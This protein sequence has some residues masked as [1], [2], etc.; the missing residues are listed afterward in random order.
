MRPLSGADLLA[1]WTEFASQLC[2]ASLCSKENAAICRHYSESVLKRGTYNSS[3]VGLTIG[4]LVEK[5]G[6]FLKIPDSEIHQP[7]QQRDLKY[8]LPNFHR[9]P[10]RGGGGE[11]GRE[12]GEREGG[13]G[14]EGGGLERERGV[15]QTCLLLCELPQFSSPG[16]MLRPFICWPG[17]LWL[18]HCTHMYIYTLSWGRQELLWISGFRG[19]PLITKRAGHLKGSYR[20]CIHDLLSKSHLFFIELSKDSGFFCLFFVFQFITLQPRALELLEHLYN[21]PLG[22]LSP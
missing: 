16:R 13:R 5:G 3:P 14:R 4:S 7:T 22:T 10:T 20:F 8:A 6:V 21:S 11:G 18:G 19:Q 17:S 1:V 2:F 9:N 12:G 15:S